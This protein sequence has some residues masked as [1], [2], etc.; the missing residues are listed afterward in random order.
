M[1]QTAE[2]LE[3]ECSILGTAI[4]TGECTAEILTSLTVED[5]G[6]DV[7][8]SI[9]AALRALFAR[10]SPIDRITVIHE[11]GSDDYGEFIDG[12]IRTRLPQTNLSVY[13]QLLR[14]RSRL[15][16]IKDHATAISL[17]ENLKEVTPA[18]EAINTLMMARRQWKGIGMLDAMNS[19]VDRLS[20][21]TPPVF[22][23]TGFQRLDAELYMQPGDMVVIGGE[24]SSGKT[25]LATQFAVTL[26][27]AGYRVGFFSL[28][29]SAEKLTDRIM[30]QQGQIPLSGIK[31]KA[32]SPEE[33]KKA[34]ETAQSLS[35]LALEIIPAA[36]MS[37]SD[38]QA[39][40]LARS[41]DVIFVDYLQIIADASESR[42][43]AVTRISIALHTLSQS[44]GI[45]VFALAQLSR[46]EK[47][48]RTKD[49][50][51]EAYAPTMH[52]LKESGQ[53]EQD[54]DI[55]LLLYKERYDGQYDSPRKLKIG[56][57]KEGRLKIIDLKF[58]GSTLTFSEDEPDHWVYAEAANQKKNGELIRGR[59]KPSAPADDTK[60]EQL[61]AFIKETF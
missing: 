31:Q 18:L 19:F 46:P 57:N 35:G 7:T 41:F 36:G 49:G 23:K 32:L 24:P 29:T 55:V 21:S 43:E 11:L 34:A 58:T 14:E 12:C 4:R 54:A 28:E 9:F 37:V 47:P 30:A 15:D 52:D 3:L 25:V 5:F 39:Y 61:S 45:T 42:Y 56:K 26:A 10:G 17:M 22:L 51:L 16:E 33:W 44:N 59:E 6:H 50:K 60:F 20:D 27:K 8:K 48:K 40:S 13:L 53:V 1:K 38:I 2:R